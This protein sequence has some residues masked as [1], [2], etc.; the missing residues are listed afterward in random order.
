MDMIKLLLKL[1]APSFGLAI[2]LRSVYSL[3][4]TFIQI[5]NPLE[6]EFWDVY[7]DFFQFMGPTFIVWVLITYGVCCLI[8]IFLRKT[9]RSI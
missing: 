6:S 1:I 8:Y 2:L 7:I 9:S 5:N 4:K 3:V